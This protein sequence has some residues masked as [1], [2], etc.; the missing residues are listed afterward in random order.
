MTTEQRQ[1]FDNLDPSIIDEVSRFS[2]IA[3]VLQARAESQYPD[4]TPAEA[5]VQAAC[6]DFAAYEARKVSIVGSLKPQP[7]MPKITHTPE[8]E[9]PIS[10]VTE[11]KRVAKTYGAKAEIVDMEDAIAS[12]NAA[13]NV[14][15]RLGRFSRN[16]VNP[17]L[18]TLDLLNAQDMDEAQRARR[19]GI[20]QTISGLIIRSI[21][22]V[23]PEAIQAK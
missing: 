3:Q 13:E 6:D 9:D 8:G 23:G 12:S 11:I 19:D 2:L 18:V 5:A 4:Q 15:A 21:I 17:F 22:V 7:F 16:Y 1:K 10:F 14:N 20:H